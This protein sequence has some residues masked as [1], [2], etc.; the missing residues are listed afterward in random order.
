MSDTRLQLLLAAAGEALRE[1][2]R[3]RDE[4]VEAHVPMTQHPKPENIPEREV[5][6]VLM[7]AACGT[8]CLGRGVSVGVDVKGVIEDIAV[9]PAAGNWHG[10]L[11]RR[12]MRSYGFDEAATDRLALPD[13]T[14][15]RALLSA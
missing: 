8:E 10:D 13:F 12:V 3:Y 14:A 6:A 11:A 4:L 15:E 9:S 1:L 5:R 7:R 2:Q